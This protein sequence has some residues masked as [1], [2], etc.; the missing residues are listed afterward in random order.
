M[1]QKFKSRKFI[2]AVVGALISLVNAI[3]DALGYPSIPVEQVL[4]I[5]SPLIAFILG[6]AYVDGNRK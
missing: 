5:I 4:A 1:L 2:L 3:L 6:E